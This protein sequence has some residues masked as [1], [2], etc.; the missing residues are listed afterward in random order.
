MAAAVVVNTFSSSL[1][2]PHPGAACLALG[3]HGSTAPGVQA[4]VLVLGLLLARFQDLKL[5]K[6]LNNLSCP[7]SQ[8]NVKEPFS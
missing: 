8:N 7:K 4:L 5:I 6:I 3:G 1:L 2:P